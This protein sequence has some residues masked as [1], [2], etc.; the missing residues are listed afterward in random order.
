MQATTALIREFW[1]FF[2]RN[3]SRI[4]EKSIIEIMYLPST[5]RLLFPKS[6]PI[7]VA[8]T[9]A[10]VPSKP[11]FAATKENP[12]GVA[13]PIRLVLESKN[14]HMHF[15]A[16]VVKLLFLKSFNA[17]AV[18]KLRGF[19]SRFR[20]GLRLGKLIEKIILSYSVCVILTFAV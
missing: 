6:N 4:S 14:A 9:Q 19:F 5:N 1:S 2:G 15:K 7:M 3:L 8:N 13:P 16:T 17:V 18:K 20:I 12:R 10:Y 11:K